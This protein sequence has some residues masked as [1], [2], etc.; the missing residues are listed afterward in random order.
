M[1]N[2]VVEFK[3]DVLSNKDITVLIRTIGKLNISI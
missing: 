1:S 2:L 3:A